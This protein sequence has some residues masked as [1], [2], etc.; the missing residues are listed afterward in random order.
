MWGTQSA[1]N[2]EPSYEVWGTQSAQNLEPSYEVV[3]NTECAES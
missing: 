3:G 2:L 1:P